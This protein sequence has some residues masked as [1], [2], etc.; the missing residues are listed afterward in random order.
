[1]DS[2]GLEDSTSL[3]QPKSKEKCWIHCKWGKIICKCNGGN[4]MDLN[5][6]MFGTLAIFYLLKIKDNLG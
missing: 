4:G 6:A 2:A 1:M 5:F 3:D